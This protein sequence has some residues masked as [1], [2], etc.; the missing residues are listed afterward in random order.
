MVDEKL[1]NEHIVDYSTFTDEELKHKKAIED[2]KGWLGESKYATYFSVCKESIMK[3]PN[4]LPSYKF[5]RIGIG[6][7]L[8]VD[9]YPITAFFNEIRMS[10]NLPPLTEAEAAN[11]YTD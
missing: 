11:T 8:G 7:F 4:N 3:D 9:G 6:L 10:L 5:L 2:L 1:S